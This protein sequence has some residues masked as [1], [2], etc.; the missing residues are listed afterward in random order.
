VRQIKHVRL[1]MSAKSVGL[2]WNSVV[3]LT[4]SWWMGVMAAL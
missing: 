4:A 3:S 1:V 2:M